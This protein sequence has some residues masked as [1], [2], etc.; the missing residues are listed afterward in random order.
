MRDYAEVR[1][2]GV[3]TGEVAAQA[4]DLLEID[5]LGLDDIDRRV[6]RTIIEKFE[7]GPVG[8]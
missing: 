5:P 2:G 1:A 7:G 8:L 6:L 3:I 4:L